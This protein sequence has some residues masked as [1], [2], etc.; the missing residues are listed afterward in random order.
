MARPAELKAGLPA[1]R[2]SDRATATAA[3]AAAGLGDPPKGR[4]PAHLRPC[5][6]GKVLSGRGRTPVPEERQPNDLGVRGAERGGQCPA[7]AVFSR[8]IKADVK[9]L[10][11]AIA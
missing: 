6:C 9:I 3:R 1:G 11:R 8:H 2:C 4:R 5:Q 10:R 7:V